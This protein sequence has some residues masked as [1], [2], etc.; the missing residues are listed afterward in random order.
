[1]SNKDY[2]AAGDS[3]HFTYFAQ[4][5]SLPPSSPHIKPRNELDLAK[6]PCQ[7]MIIPIENRSESVFSPSQ[8]EN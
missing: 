7:V 1:M 5:S 6:P 4:P 2:L 8:L 3:R